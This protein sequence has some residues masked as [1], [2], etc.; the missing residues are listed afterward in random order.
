[1]KNY[2]NFKCNTCPNLCRQSQQWYFSRIRHSLC[3]APVKILFTKLLF[4]VII[5]ELRDAGIQ[6][7]LFEPLLKSKYLYFGRRMH[8]K[9]FV[10]DANFS[11]V[12]GINI[13]NRY[14][15]M[16]EEDAWL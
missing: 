9:I 3:H 7:R 12:G 14:N 16:P 1:M 2:I 8:H 11:L 5:D 10:A 6:F 15:D 13:P 4:W